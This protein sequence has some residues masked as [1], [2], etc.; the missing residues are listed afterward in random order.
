[1]RVSVSS[2]VTY[3]K[4]FMAFL[5]I[6]AALFAQ[7]LLQLN[8]PAV[9]AA[10]PSWSPATLTLLSGETKTTTTN[11]D[12]Y[13]G[14]SMSFHYDIGNLESTDNDTLDYGW[15]DGIGGSDHPLGS[16]LGES[17]NPGP[18]EVGD[19]T[20]NLPEAAGVSD[21][22]FYFT[23]TG[24][25][26][27]ANDEV[28]VSALTIS[29]TAPVVATAV[30]NMSTGNTY[31][32]L[33][34]AVVAAAST[35]TLRVN[36]NLTLSHRVNIT[37]SLTIDGAGHTISSSFNGPGTANDNNAAFALL[38]DN[39]HLANMSIDGSASSALN[40]VVAYEVVGASL[41]NVTLSNNDKYGLVV[42]G[43]TVSVNN[44]M[45]A[46]NAWGGINVDQGSG[47]SQS[48]ELTVNGTSSHT[49]AAAIYVDNDTKAVSVNAPA[50]TWARSGATGHEHDRVYSLKIFQACNG[51]TFDTG[52][53]NGS[54]NGQN[55]WKSTGGY[56]QEVVD[57]TYG[58]A[59]LGCKTLRLSNGVARGSFGDQTYTPAAAARAGES[60][61]N[62]HYE[63]SFTF[64]STMQTQQSNLAISVSPDDG[65]GNRMSYVGLSDAVSGTELTF[66]D[67]DSDGNFVATS[68]GTFARD[69]AHTIKFVIDFVPGASND[70]V[71]LYVDGVLAHTGTTWEQYYRE[72]PEQAGNGNVVP[73]VDRLAL[74]ARTTSVPTNMGNGYLFDNIQVST[75]QNIPAPVIKTVD[76]ASVEQGEVT[77]TVTLDK[78]S[79]IDLNHNYTFVKFAAGRDLVG[80]ALANSTKYAFTKVA[81]A[82]YRAIF[83]S[84]DFVPV[85][86]EG[87]YSV[88]VSMQDTVKGKDV[89]NLKRSVVDN[90]APAITNVTVGNPAHGTVNVDV[91]LDESHGVL[92]DDRYT[93]VKFVAGRDLSVGA[94]ANSAKYKLTHVAGNVY[95][96]TVATSDFAAQGTGRYVLYVSAQDTL[97]NKRAD[98]STRDIVI[99]N[100][101]PVVPQIMS[102]GARTWHKGSSL[103]NSWT[104]S[105]DA[106]G[107]KQYQVKYVFDGG[108]TATRLVAGT[109]RLQ[110]FSGSY[111]GAITISVR[112]QDNAGNWSDYSAPV[113]YHYDSVLPETTIVAPTSTTDGTFT[114]SGHATDNL[115]L[116]RVYVQLVNRDDNQRYGGTTISLIADG[117]SSDWARDYAAS[118]DNLP[119]G[120]YA[121]HVTIVDMAGNVAYAGWTDNFIVDGTAP[122]VTISQPT[123]TTILAPGKV[124]IQGLVDDMTV[125]TVDV[126]F[127][128]EVKQATVNP[129]TGEW[130]VLFTGVPAGQHTLTV[131][132]VDDS[133]NIGEATLASVPVD[134]NPIGIVV[135]VDPNTQNPQARPVTRGGTVTTTQTPAQQLTGFGFGTPQATTAVQDAG[136]TNR[137]GD[138][139]NAE[140]LA[141]ET[142]NTDSANKQDSAGTLAAEDRTPVSSTWGMF[143]LAW[144]WW[145]L[146]VAGL[147][148][149]VYAVRRA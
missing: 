32:T 60:A 11:V 134:A 102:P 97:G 55:G 110:T 64:G 86:S 61:V 23:N 128:G 43:S 129:S 112:A 123:K 5:F 3:A 125:D 149:T 17:N 90:N 40:G 63:A 121:A 101:A 111:Q 45:T 14:L 92:E 69:Q 95:R 8:L 131:T 46:N 144:Y 56:D 106:S 27:N 33:Q 9:F 81:P 26:S 108:A 82:T 1:M 44:I 54:V 31:D 99:D 136:V 19:K 12:G 132:A 47:V 20:V 105:T 133:G 36:E 53:S 76:V 89:N 16:L 141:D 119:D 48:A 120:T 79:D 116:N 29:G 100:Q 22:V 91:T 137:V 135:P 57:N 109:S 147:G 10:G 49:E 4:R 52:F 145:L 42:N 30:T 98:N 25:S 103:L 80:S 83:D 72:S 138:K 140:V 37:K 66:F 2:K 148:S 28:T 35:N 107:I 104:A 77:V 70:V 71:K 124:T 68:L 34:E 142:T 58:Y 38:A 41:D 39:V 117:T 93:F 13:S 114:I 67:T 75:T 130:S 59:G 96:A 21:L 122:V 50:Y 143:G 6:A 87:N 88:Y 118:T 85:D 51:S 15:R 18:N 62:D 74:L 65:S 94:L 24:S 146:I 73:T 126:I 113:T 78:D 139:T 127:N 115:Q 84:R 7:P